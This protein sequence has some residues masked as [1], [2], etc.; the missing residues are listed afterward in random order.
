MHLHD[1]F[2]PRRPRDPLEAIAAQIAELRD[3][4]R[5]INR[6]LSHGATDMAGDFGHAVTDWGREAAKQGAWFAGVASAKALK[7][8]R[9]VKRDPLPVIAVLGTAILL[10]SLL[11]QRR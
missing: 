6:S 9:A 1:I 5:Q 8:A 7:G 4:A 11:R 10:A 3:Q 2:P